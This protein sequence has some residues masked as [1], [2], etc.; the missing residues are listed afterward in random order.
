MKGK[1]VNYAKVHQCL[2]PIMG[3][4]TAEA[5]GIG[6]AVGAYDDVLMIWEQ[7]ISGD[8]L[9]GSLYWIVT[10]EESASLATGYTTIADA[11]L[12]GGY[13]SH[14]IDAAAEDPTTL[15]RQYIGSKA[16]VRMIAT[17][18]GTHTNGTPL[19]AVILLGSPRKAPVTQPTE[20]GTDTSS[21]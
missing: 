6:V 16:Y 8:T 13:G 10:F 15:V 11:D 21:G 2:V 3:N 9:S 20:L 4:T 7:G 19:S 12:I 1:L 17:Q 18:T 14:T 5:T